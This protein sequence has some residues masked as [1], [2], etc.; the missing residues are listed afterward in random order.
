[1][2]ITG[3]IVMKFVSKNYYRYL[4]PK[5]VVC[6]QERAPE[7]DMKEKE[8]FEISVPEYFWNSLSQKFEYILK[9]QPWIVMFFG[10][11]SSKM[12]KQT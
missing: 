11:I 6:N 9:L 3:K 12:S 5:Y 2:C 7:W 1:M 8:N 10:I 4:F